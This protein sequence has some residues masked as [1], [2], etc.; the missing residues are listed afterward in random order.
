M[1][2]L[3]W[4]QMFQPQPVLVDL[5][6]VS[7]P[8]RP[9]FQLFFQSRFQSLRSPWPAVGK[10]NGS[11]R[12]QN[13]NQEI[14]VPVWLCACAGDCSETNK[15]STANQ[16]QLPLWQFFQNSPEV[17]I[18]GADQKDRSLWGRHCCFSW[19]LLIS[20]Q[21]HFI[22]L[23][24][25]LGLIKLSGLLLKKTLFLAWFGWTDCWILINRCQ[26]NSLNCFNLGT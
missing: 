23:C 1:S 22:S 5:V 26:V 20:I 16:I 25:K 13:R 18:P 12:I 24:F 15:F 7:C 11:G 6:E 8:K 9:L 14:L 2:H 19:K 21:M 4:D 10:L 3:I 17:P